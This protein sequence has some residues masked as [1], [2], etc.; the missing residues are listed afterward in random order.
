MEQQEIINL[1]MFEEEIYNDFEK[2]LE[3]IVIE[4]FQKYNNELKCKH[5]YSLRITKTPTRTNYH[6]FD[7][8][9]LH[10]FSRKLINGMT[11]LG[12]IPNRKFW[13]KYF[14]G[15]VRTISINQNDSNEFPSFNLNHLVYSDYDNLDVRIISQLSTRIKKI[16]PTLILKFEYIGSYDISIIKKNLDFMTKI[17]FESFPAE[18]LGKRNLDFIVF[19]PLQKPRFLGSLFKPNRN[20]LIKESKS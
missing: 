16:D 12:T 2:Q 9:K 19:N 1:P 17:D 10:D 20:L 7:F 8:E 11:S 5:L 15:G 6:T 14:D 3:N 18:K 13:N 4:R